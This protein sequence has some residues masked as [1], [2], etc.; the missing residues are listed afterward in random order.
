MKLEYPF[1][2]VFT[3][4][5]LNNGSQGRKQVVLVSGTYKTCM[6]YARYLMCVK[7]QRFLNTLEHVDHIDDDKSND[8]LDNLQILFPWDN[9]IKEGARRGRLLAI[10]ECPICKKV[11]TVRKGNSQAVP[12]KRGTIRFCKP[13]CR[14][15][16]NYSLYSSDELKAIS[17]NSLLD[18]KRIH[19]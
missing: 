1:T 15:S 9:N 18:V 16:F 12:S 13:I 14:E 11:F 10:I 19:G 4:A 8:N 17:E 7:E 3:S 2:E 5:H 6:S